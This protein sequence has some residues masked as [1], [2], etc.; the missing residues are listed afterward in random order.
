MKTLFLTLEFPPQ[1][2]GVEN[3]YGNIARYWPEEL[4]VLNN[5]QNE[6]ISQKLPFLRWLKAL[7]PVRAALKQ[8]RPQW[9]LVGE[10][11]PLGTVAWLLSFMTPFK[12]AVILHGLDFSLATQSF[13]KRTLSKYILTKASLVI[14]ANTHTAEEVQRTFPNLKNISVV[15]PGVEI[16]IPQISPEEASSFKAKQGLENA[17][18]LLTV[19]R[20]VKR[21]GVDMVLNA[22]TESI[23]QMPNLHYIIIGDG[24]EKPYLENIIHQLGLSNNVRIISGVNDEEKNYW[25]ASCDIF[26]MP[27]RNINGDY[28]GFGI[29]YLEA[30][31]FSKPVIAGLSGG[32]SEAVQ[33]GI[34]GLVVNEE[35]VASIAQAI[36]TLYN[37]K[38]LRGRLGQAG[39]RQSLEQSWSKQVAKIHS[40]LT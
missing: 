27:A 14:C 35:D 9:L 18:V 24:P 13:L 34:N 4:V 36:L 39:H 1:V 15:N 29:V 19:G 20:L 28:E 11:L 5:N 16:N 37:D 23:S 31:L 7:K 25:L 26:I 30:G 12:Y 3:Y 8:N 17:L 38:E 40:L 21:K 22:L 2:G 6:L 10:I 32:V 33:S